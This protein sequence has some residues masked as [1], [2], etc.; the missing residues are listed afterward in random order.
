MYFWNNVLFAFHLLCYDRTSG[1]MYG[2]GRGNTNVNMSTKSVFVHKAYQDTLATEQNML[3]AHRTT[4]LPLMFTCNTTAD[5]NNSQ[6]CSHRRCTSKDQPLSPL[7]HREIPMH[8]LIKTSRT[9]NKEWSFEVLSTI[10]IH[11]PKMRINW[12]N[13][14]TVEPNLSHKCTIHYSLNY[15]NSSP[16]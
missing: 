15:S 16:M 2:R 11:L 9:K 6:S 12:T 1:Y 3:L 5:Q 10:I 4:Q 14:S 7:T 8:T 13:L